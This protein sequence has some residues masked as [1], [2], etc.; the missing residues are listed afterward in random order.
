MGDWLLVVEAGT[1]LPL[2]WHAAVGDHVRRRPDQTAAI[3]G[4]KAGLLSGRPVLALVIPRSAYAKAGGF[5][6]ADAGLAS[7]L[8]RLERSGKAARL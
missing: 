6:A 8:R 3:L 2:N 5:T 7:L 1:R 4:D